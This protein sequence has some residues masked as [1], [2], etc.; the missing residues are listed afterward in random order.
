VIFNREEMGTGFRRKAGS[1]TVPYFSQ[2]FI[3]QNH[4]DIATCVCMVFIAGLMFQ[5]SSPFASN[6]I[7]PK[8]NTT[9]LDAPVVHYTYGLKDLCL[10]FF[11]T[12][13]A[14]IF[15]AV[16]QEYVL[17]KLMRK[18][19]L[20]KTKANKFNE[21]GQLLAFY[22]LSVAWA[23]YVF[24]EEGYFQTLSF[25][26]TDYPHVGITFMTKFFFIIQMSYWIHVFPELY[27]QKVKKED[28]TAKIVFATIHFAICAAIYYLK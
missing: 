28:M 18:V 14:I 23:L 8:Y 3:I 7:A 22:T 12:I 26:W 27:F 6:F 10:V 11:Y 16:I 24:R 15:H 2:E 21:S 4:G 19:R 9:E 5:V 20:S 17:D 13:A 25:F 1:K